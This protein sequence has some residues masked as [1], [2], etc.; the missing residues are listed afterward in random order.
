MTTSLFNAYQ[1]DYLEGMV[2]VKLQI[3]FTRYE[4][5]PSNINAEC[6]SLTMS[7]FCLNNLWDLYPN[8]YHKLTLKNNVLKPTKKF[9]LG[10]THFYPN[11]TT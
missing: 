5:S 11:L 3:P 4:I 9:A 1:F 7:I 6:L 8:K 2:D 10:T